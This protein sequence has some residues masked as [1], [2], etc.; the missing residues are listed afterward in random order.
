MKPTL[1]PPP[2]LALPGAQGDTLIMTSRQWPAKRQEILRRVEPLLADVSRTVPPL[3]PQ[4]LAQDDRGDFIEQQVRYGAEI[5]E[6]CTATLL[7]PKPLSHRQPAVLCC[8]YDGANTS[9]TLT[10]ELVKRR[11]VVLAPHERKLPAGKA[12]WDHQRGLDFLCHLDAVDSDRLATIGQGRGGANAIILSAFDHRIK[13]GAAACAYAPTAVAAPEVWSGFL[14]AGE[15]PVCD[16][17]EILALTAPRAFHYTYALQDE[18]LPHSEA[19]RNDMI[20]LGRLY[21]L[22]GCR[23]KFSTFESPDGH[24]YPTAA[25]REAYGVLKRVLQDRR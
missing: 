4:V 2:L 20:E 8:P 21:D 9:A 24:G 7:L 19:V 3:E 17:I 1:T 25:R 14:E 22:L 10:K 16:W 23:D 11:F 15:P 12:L 13:A 6:T 5:H 18:T